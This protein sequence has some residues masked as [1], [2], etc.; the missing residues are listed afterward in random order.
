KVDGKLLFEK[1]F[2][3]AERSVNEKWDAAKSKAETRK[4]ITGYLATA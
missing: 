3:L 4:V 2:E 1:L